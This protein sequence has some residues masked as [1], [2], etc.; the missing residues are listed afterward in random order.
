MVKS[1]EKGKNGLNTGK[2]NRT[3]HDQF[4]KALLICG[5]NWGACKKFIPTRTVTQLKSHSQKYERIL[6]KNGSNEKILHILKR[7]S[8]VKKKYNESEQPPLEGHKK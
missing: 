3:E 7:R 2:W 1:F 8:E 4:V 5:T 6:A